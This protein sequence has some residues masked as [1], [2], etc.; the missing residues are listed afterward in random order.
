MLFYKALLPLAIR[1][2][3]FTY[4]TLQ[5]VFKYGYQLFLAS[6]GMNRFYSV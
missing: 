2:Y 4:Y 5:A 1:F 6:K 3:I